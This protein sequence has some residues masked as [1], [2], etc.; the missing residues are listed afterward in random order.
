MA[1]E[2]YLV[3]P[4][5]ASMVTHP[6]NTLAQYITNLP[7]RISLSG[8]WE[9]GLTEI[10]YPHDWYNVRNARLTVE[11]DGNVET[12]T[13]L[14]DGY[15]HSP[16]AL[17]T[18][19]NGDKPG[20]VKFAYEPVTQKFVAHVKSETKV[21]L[22]G[23]LPDILGFGSGG[24][25]T[26][27]ASA[28]RSMFLRAHSIVDLRRG[29]ESLYVYSSI[30]EPRIVGDKI[31]PL[32]RIV[33]ISGRHGE[34]VTARFDHVQYI[35]LMSREFGNV[36]TEIRD[37]TGRPVPFERGDGDASLSTVQL[38]T[39]QMNYDDYYAR[40][41]GGA[42]PY[43]TGARVQRGH[44]F[45]S[46]F[47]GLLRTVAPLIRRGAVALGKRALTTGAQIA[48]DVVAGKNVKKAAK[49]RAT[50]AGRNLMQSLLNTPPPPGKRI[51]RIKR[52]VP[53]R[54]VTPIKRRQRTDVFS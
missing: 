44:G 11:H 54:R 5:N 47:S 6:N 39:I 9:C 14:E 32:L 24:S 36:E 22:Y 17:A 40:Q 16:K 15:Y 35:P 37:D 27:L 20:R 42:L 31:A 13:Y 21:T 45:G 29:F 1:S 41:V 34:M 30:V 19:L 8:T 49:R 50:A 12:D 26:S 53:H 4:S 2:F 48:S 52:T 10:H 43:F 28:A 46:L 23:D 3:L 51:K 33:P 25:N 18:T 7:R 38:P